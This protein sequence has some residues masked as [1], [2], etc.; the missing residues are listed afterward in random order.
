MEVF[1]R[2]NRSLV[3]KREQL[4]NDMVLIR[5]AKSIIVVGIVC[6][7]GCTPRADLSDLRSFTVEAFKDEKPDV[8]PLPLIEPYESVSYSSETLVNPFLSLNN[9]GK[10]Q[11]KS[12]IDFN[13][14]FEPERRRE[15]LEGFP[16]DALKMLGTL[17][18]D[19]QAWVLV[20]TPDGGTHRV[21]LGNYLGRRSGKII[22]I[23]E[24]EVLLR[25]I[26]KNPTGQWE[27]RKVTLNF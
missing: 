3:R 21:T 24:Q 23:N 9:R 19:D 11:V 17:F 7:Y 16:L 18:Q 26:V 20:S 10:E 12:S 8:E 14:V 22:N 6:I 4:G 5:L 27:E 1:R 2:L 13:E 25:E 15:V